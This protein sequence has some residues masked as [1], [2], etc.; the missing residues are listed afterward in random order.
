MNLA[1]LAIV[2]AVVLFALVAATVAPVSPFLYI[3]L[4]CFAAGHLPLP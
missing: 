1:L 3:G 4:A 2:A